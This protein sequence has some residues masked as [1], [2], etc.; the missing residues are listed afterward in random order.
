[1]TKNSENLSFKMAT[2][3]TQAASCW[4]RH[5]IVNIHQPLHCTALFD[6]DHFPNGDEAAMRS[7]LC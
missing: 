6:V 7:N 1:M 5:L 3:Q 4:L 2:P